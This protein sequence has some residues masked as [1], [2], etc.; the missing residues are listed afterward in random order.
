MV[1]HVILQIL[2]RELLVRHN[3][4][5]HI[6]GIGIHT[7]SPVKILAHVLMVIEE[8]PYTGLAVAAAAEIGLG[9]SHLPVEVLVFTSEPTHLAG[10]LN[11][12]LRVDDLGIVAGHNTNAALIGVARNGIVGNAD[13]APHD[14]SILASALHLHDP[15]LVGV[16]EREGL[17]LRAVA[18]GL[19]QGCHHLDGLAGRLR[20]LQSKIDERPI[21][22]A[23]FGIDHL[24]TTAICSLANG[25]LI[26]IDVS[27]D[28]VGLFS[29]RNLSDVF[30]A[31]PVHDVAHR[32]FGM[33]GGGVVAEANEHAVVIGIVS[34]H[35]ATIG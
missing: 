29:L 7:Q 14:S 26:F 22:D 1:A 9:I 8:R 23:A 10:V 19:G 30:V 35:D 6:G 27:D 32:A 33:S 4:E 3:P 15:G 13:G 5:R 28:I 17:S 34:T 25:H 12:V 20:A 2:E 16:A 18:I 11:H 24:L 31:V 21:I